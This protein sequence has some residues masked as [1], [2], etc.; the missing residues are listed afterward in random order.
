MRTEQGREELTLDE[1]GAWDR[2]WQRTYQQLKRK[3]ATTAVARESAVAEGWRVV[4]H[5]RAGGEEPFMGRRR[6]PA[7][8]R[9]M[10]SRVH[11]HATRSVSLPRD[12]YVAAYRNAE[13]TGESVEDWVARAI[14]A[15]VDVTTLASTKGAVPANATPKRASEA[16]ASAADAQELGQRMA[17]VET[18]L[19]ELVRTIGVDAP[20]R[21]MEEAHQAAELGARTRARK[22]QAAS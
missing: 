5:M 16:A 11:T 19:G 12:A 15:F 6:M 3:G 4:E 20:D 7:K 1:R 10:M 18:L 2:A 9:G 17:R 14:M 22:R 8:M 13:S 21:M